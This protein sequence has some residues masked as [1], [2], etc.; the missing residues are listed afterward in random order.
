MEKVHFG[1]RKG[2]LSLLTPLFGPNENFPTW[3]GFSY[4]KYISEYFQRN[5][6]FEPFWS[7]KRAFGPI[8]EE[9]KGIFPKNPALLRF[10]IYGALTSSEVSEK[11]MERIPRKVRY[12]DINGLTD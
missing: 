4:M 7:K 11:T 5:V 9:K 3:N 12:R 8:W 2:L 10:Y 1:P 6:H